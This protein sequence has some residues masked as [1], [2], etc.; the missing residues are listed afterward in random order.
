MKQT[1]NRHSLEDIRISGGIAFS[2][3]S[4]ILFFLFASPARGQS[5]DLWS[6]TGGSQWLTG[7]N[8]TTGN[9]PGTLDIGQFAANPTGG[10]TI[11]IKFDNPTNN[12]AANEAVGAIDVTTGRPNSI[13]FTNNST[14]TAGVLTLNGATV[15]T[16]AGSLSNVILHSASTGG[17]N[18]T[19]QDGSSE[20]MALALG[21][22]T[23]N[24]VVL[25]ATGGGNINIGDII[26]S[27]SARTP[28]TF[29]GSGSN[30][31]TVNITGV[32]NTFTGTISILGNGTSTT[33]VR[34]RPPAASATRATRL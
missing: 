23:N 33:E 3:G 2:A 1:L 14:T 26:E 24:I 27:A 21:D 32:S 20:P 7:T 17:H 5:T 16:T 8:W 4:L 30:S 11:N 6:N 13:T 22:A 9:P 10:A 18:L 34:F 31:D 28:L 19:I 15:N 29:E 25:D 12:G